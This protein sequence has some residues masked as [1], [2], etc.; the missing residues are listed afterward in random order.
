[1]YGMWH[2]YSVGCVMDYLLFYFLICIRA[3]AITSTTFIVYKWYMHCICNTYYTQCIYVSVCVLYK[4][5]MWL[6][7]L[8]V[9]TVC[10]R[11]VLM[12]NMGGCTLVVPHT[13]VQYVLY[14]HTYI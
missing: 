5:Y 4:Q 10:M 12:V 1:M 11:I 7:L 13:C 6:N 14:I 2:L 9:G 3:Y 8:Y